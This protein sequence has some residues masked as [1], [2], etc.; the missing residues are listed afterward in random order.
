MNSWWSNI[1][2]LRRMAD[3][4]SLLCLLFFASVSVSW[5]S[6]REAFDIFTI[7]FQGDTRFITLDNV[8]MSLSQELDGNWFNV[9]LYRL[10]QAFLLMP[11]I[12]EASIRR[13]WPH[14]LLVRLKAYHA[15]AIWVKTGQLM[16]D[17]AE[18]FAAN[19]AEVNRHLPILDGPVGTE[20][21]VL[22]QYQAFSQWFA[23]IG[24]FPEVV[25]LS[26]RHAWTVSLSNGT[27]V[28]L[29]RQIDGNTL[30]ERSKRLIK[31]WP[32]IVNIWGNGINYI[33]LRYSNGFAVAPE[34]MQA[35]EKRR[36]AY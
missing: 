1:R 2:L 10:R 12:K 20:R 8:Q 4:L 6:K 34:L 29:G 27:L 35:S 30:Y 22:S 33:D 18:L 5:L 11:W 3:G 32:V 26:S 19:P 15:V 25:K 31:S 28:K 9:D 14:Q 36:F 7:Y 13:V 23:E 17:D 21:Q 16:S 24:L